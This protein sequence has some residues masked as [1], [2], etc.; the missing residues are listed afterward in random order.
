[1]KKEVGKI[2]LFFDHVGSG[3][4]SATPGELKGFTIAG[5][6]KQFRTD[7]FEK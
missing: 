3:L 4:I 5:S 2:R 6:D 7:D 1:M